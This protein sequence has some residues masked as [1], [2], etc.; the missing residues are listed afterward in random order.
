MASASNGASAE[1][2]A[3]RPAAVGRQAVSADSNACV[4]SV[5]RRRSSQDE[6][7]ACHAQLLVC[8][9]ICTY[10]CIFIY[11]IYVYTYVCMCVYIYIYHNYIRRTHIIS[12]GENQQV[13][14]TREPNGQALYY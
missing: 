7:C 9:H 4:A 8:V 2:Y 10:M 6:L 12:L 1:G 14:Y 5:P 11:Y 3:S 13:E